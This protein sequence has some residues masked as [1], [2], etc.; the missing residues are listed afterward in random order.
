MSVTGIVW[1]KRFPVAVINNDVVAPGDQLAAGI[2]VKAI[3]ADKVILA[4]HDRPVTLELKHL[5][6][7]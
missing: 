5:E 7:Q 2:V 3:E 1:D 4:V 6:E